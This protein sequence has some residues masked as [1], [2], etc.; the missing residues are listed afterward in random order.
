MLMIGCN[1]LYDNKKKLIISILIYEASCIMDVIAE[2]ELRLLFFHDITL[3]FK[4]YISKNKKVHWHLRII[5]KCISC[6]K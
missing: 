1:N 5:L 4:K 2:E 6:K 3:L